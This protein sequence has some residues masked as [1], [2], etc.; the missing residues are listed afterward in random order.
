MSLDEVFTFS[1]V[2][3]VLI[4]QKKANLICDIDH[5]LRISMNDIGLGLYGYLNVQE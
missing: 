3:L 2:L 5:H 1:S 4:R